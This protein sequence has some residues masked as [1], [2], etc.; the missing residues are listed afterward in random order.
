MTPDLE[1]QAPPRSDLGLSTSPPRP[2]PPS[3]PS[4]IAGSLYERAQGVTWRVLSV[5]AS[6]VSYEVVGMD[7]EQHEVSLEQW[8]RLQKRGGLK[9]PSMAQQRLSPRDAA[10]LGAVV[11]LAGDGWCQAARGRRLDVSGLTWGQWRGAQ[12]AA[13]DRGHVELGQADHAKG[14]ADPIRLTP[15]GLAALDQHRSAQVQHTP[16]HRSSTPPEYEAKSSP[17][18]KKEE[19]APPK[20]PLP[21]EEPAQVTSTGP[22]Q[23][24]WPQRQVVVIELGPETRNALVSAL[25]GVPLCPCG[26]PMVERERGKDGVGFLACVRGKAGC[27]AT[28]A[29]PRAR[30]SQGQRTKTLIERDKAETPLEAHA[31]RLSEAKAAPTTTGPAKR[32]SA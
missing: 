4:P 2:S 12:A 31:R 8:A 29:L 25:L 32:P 3:P 21:K 30:S 28:A 1:A 20:A 22:A 15:R 27:G 10:Y 17:E 18:N 11:H 9:L 6:S 23:V 7:G 14:E 13:L 16:Q 24:A 19:I 26:L 5:S